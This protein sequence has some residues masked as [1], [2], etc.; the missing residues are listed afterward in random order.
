MHCKNT[1]THR[2]GR[3]GFTLIELLVVIAIIGL[4]ATLLLP[5]LSRAKDRAQLALDL[6][7]VKQVLLANHLYAGDNDDNK[8]HR[9]GYVDRL[10]AQAKR[11]EQIRKETAGRETHVQTEIRKRELDR[12]RSEELHRLNGGAA[13]ETTT[14]V[15][16]GCTVAWRQ[17]VLR[18]RGAP[19]GPYRIL[20]E[21]ICFE[22]CLHRMT[23]ECVTFD[24]C[25]D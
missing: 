22:L 1:K 15:R 4:L 9:A 8:S 14:R 25:K 12:W 18:L 2:L 11:Q 6:N 24:V 7:N 19:A 13:A 17:F 21:G 16:S 20:I 3:A 5:V 10:E 23:E